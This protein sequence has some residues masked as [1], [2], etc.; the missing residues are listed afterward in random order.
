MLHHAGVVLGEQRGV[1]RTAACSDVVEGDLVGQRR[2]SG[3]GRALDDV[4]AALEEA[5]AEDGVEPGNAA[6]YPVQPGA[7]G[8]VHCCLPVTCKGSVTVKR[9]PPPGASP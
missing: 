9:A 8:V 3:A 4:Q 7:I 2:F 5:A 1:E 6:R